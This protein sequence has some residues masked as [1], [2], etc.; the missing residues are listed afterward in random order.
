MSCV[1]IPQISLDCHPHMRLHQ[2]EMRY[3]RSHYPRITADYFTLPYLCAAPAPLN[4]YEG[5][6]RMRGHSKL[7]QWEV[8]GTRLN[9]LLFPTV[10]GKLW[11]KLN[12]CWSRRHR[13][14][15]KFSLLQRLRLKIQIQDVARLPKNWYGQSKRSR[16]P[17]STALTLKNKR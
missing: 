16:Y 11:I 1:V 17:W 13:M 9:G 3:T 6:A 12:Y 5:R 2:I 4:L 10:A 15:H 8:Q 7:H 14:I